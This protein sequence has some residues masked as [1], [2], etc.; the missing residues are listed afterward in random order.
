M[1][2][3]IAELW[4]QGKLDSAEEFY[5]SDFVMHDPGNPDRLPGPEGTKQM[6]AAM[7]AAFPDLFVTI[8]DLIAEGDKIVTRTSATGTHKG[9]YLGVAPTGKKI[10]FTGISVFRLVDGKYIEGWQS[11]DTLGVMQQLGAIPPL[12]GGER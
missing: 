9:K 4:N 8:E 2:R 10:T 1:R 3:H 11:I 12:A 5:A 6:V 7:R